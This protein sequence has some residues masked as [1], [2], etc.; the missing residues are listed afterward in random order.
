[1][2]KASKW[3]LNFLIG[4]QEKKNQALLT[5]QFTSSTNRTSHPGT[6]KVKRRWSFGRSSHRVSK[7][8]DS[9]DTTTLALKPQQNLAACVSIQAENAAATRIQAAFRAH[10]ARKALHALKSL[11]KLQALIRGHFVR[12]Q[13]NATM[14]RMHALLAIQVRARVQRIQMS[15]AAAQVENKKQSS[16]KRGSPHPNEVHRKKIYMTSNE[17][18]IVMKSTSG[19]LNHAQTDQIHQRIDHS[20]TSFSSDRRSISNRHRYNETLF[21]TPETS[22]QMPSP[23]PKSTRPYIPFQQHDSLVEP[24]C[25]EYSFMPSYMANTQSS[26]AKK[27]R[28]QSEPKQRPDGSNK[29]KSQHTELVDSRDEQFLRRSSSYLKSNDYKNHDPW[30]GKLYRPRRLFEENKYE[31]INPSHPKYTESLAS[32]PHVILY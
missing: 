16:F 19:Q 17:S 23:K 26:S 4:K 18:Q 28:S 5:D 21:I 24:I 8:A 6:P 13:T 11:V 9:I 25:Y 30:F 29:H 22:P 10:L 2:G 31:Y 32:E 20:Y 15:E 27:V 14:R 12:K 7:S 1:M 3:I